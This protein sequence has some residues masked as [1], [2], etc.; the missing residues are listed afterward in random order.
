MT[1]VRNGP[2]KPLSVF[3]SQAVDD[4]VEF[5]RAPLS[6]T[7]L[8]CSDDGNPD[9]QNLILLGGSTSQTS[10]LV[11]QLRGILS[12]QWPGSITAVCSME[13]MSSQNIT[14]DTSVLSLVDIDQPV[15]QNINGR[16]WDSLRLLLQEAGKILWVSSGRRARNPH[17][18][19]MVGLLR[20]ARLEIP[21]LVVKYLPLPT[22]SRSSGIW[23]WLDLT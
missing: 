10:R 21:T 1:P 17:A 3:V 4:R 16:A 8:N 22:L 19:M 5:L 18:N 12:P 7:M 13:D 2:V 6:S 15:F 11:T 14:S 23:D 9:K 20:A